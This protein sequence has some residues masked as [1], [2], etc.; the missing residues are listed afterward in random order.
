MNVACS[1]VWTK[2]RAQQRGC[3]TDGRCLCGAPDSLVHWLLDCARPEVQQA[4]ADAEVPQDFLDELRQHAG[5][6]GYVEGTYGYACADVPS[7]SSGTTSVILDG[8]GPT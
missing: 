3:N 7:M 4:R 2:T 5:E 8:Q 1:G 6:P